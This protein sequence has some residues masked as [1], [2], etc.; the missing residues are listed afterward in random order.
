M[1]DNKDLKQA[2]Q[3]ALGA[4]ENQPLAD[5]AL[6]LLKTLGYHSERRLVLKPN[7]AD[8]FRMEFDAERQLNEE[9]ALVSA[10]K[11]VDVLFQITDSEVQQALKN[12]QDMFASKEVN[13]ADIRSYLFF[14]VELK[15]E[16][17]TRTQLAGITREINKL[18]P[19]PV[20]VIFRYNHV[21]SLGIITRRINKHD[22]NKDVLEKV[23][24]IKD[25]RFSG[26]R[27]QI[28][29]MHD[30]AISQLVEKHDL[31]NF[32]DLQ[33][34]WEKTLDT[35]E[36]NKKFYKEIANWYFWAVKTVKFP[37]DAEKDEETR[38]A[39][40]VIRLITR[41]IFVWFIKEKG[42]VPEEL[43]DK[44]WLDAVLKYE[45]PKKS[46]Y[47]KAI[48]QNLFF[49]TLN[50]EMG[51]GRIFRRK[52]TG[53]LDPDYL[54]SN[55]YRYKQYLKNP[56]KVLELFA[57]IPFLNGGLFECLD[58]EV[59]KGT[60]I[61]IDG[62]SERE[63]NPLSV[64]DD[65]FLLEKEKE[66]DLNEIYGTKNKKYKVRGILHILN[67]YKFTIEEN[68]PIE[69]EI[70][71][72]PE[73]LGKVFENLLAAYNPETGTT[74]R[75][76]TGSFYTPR[77]IV[78]YMVDEALVA[79][80]SS[81]LG[82]Q[83]AEF[84]DRLRDLLSYNEAPHAFSE[85]ETTLLIAA[86][87]KVK[88]LDPAA[89]SGAFP[90]GVLHKLVFMLNKLDPKNERWKQKQIAKALEMDSSQS[91]EA[92][93]ASIE[94]VF[95]ENHD[96]YGRKLYLIENCIYGVD[97]QPIA[98]QIAKL[99]FFIS[100]V[101]DQKTNTK[102]PNLGI[103][104]LPNLETKFV[105]ANTLIGIQR[106][107][108]KP[109]DEAPA[110]LSPEVE[111]ACD[112]LV[113][114]LEQYLKS[115][116]PDLRA[117]YTVEAQEYADTINANMG[118]D[119]TPLN[120]NWLFTTATDTKTLKALLPKKPETKASVLVLRNQEIDQKE[121]ELERV[122]REH[123]SART[124]T[125]KR[126]YRDLDKKLRAEIS[127]LLKK[128]GWGS[129]SAQQL[130][131]WDPYNQNAHADFFDP[132]WMFG[133][134]GG[135]DVVIGNPPYVQLQK[136][137]GH[138]GK[139]F[140]KAGYNTFE[141]TGDIYSLFYERG[142]QIL[143]HKGVLCFITSNKWMR[144]GYGESTRKFF[145][146]NTNPILLIDFA[147]QKIFEAATVDVNILMFSKDKNQHKTLACTIKED[148]LSNLS[149]FVRQAG[150]ICSFTNTNSWVIL[151]DIEQRIKEKIERIG[152]PL[153]HWD[154]QIN[155][156]IKTGF[157]DAFIIDGTK[158][159]ELIAQ[160]PKSDEIIRPI[161]R[162]RDIK[163]YGYDFAD[164]WLINTHNGIKEKGI[165]PVN[166][167]EYP[168]IKKHLD[169]FWDKIE[170][171]T[172]QGDTP[173]NLRNCAYME[174]FSKQKIIYPDIMRMPRQAELLKEYPYFY[175]DVKNFYVEATNFIMTGVDI[176]LVFLFLVSDLGFY[177]FS[178]F[179]AGPQF[180]ATGFRYKKVYIDETFIPK[181]ADKQPFLSIMDRL[182]N[183]ED[184]NEQINKIWNEIIDLNPE[185]IR[186]VKEYKK[187][188]LV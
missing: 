148:V 84:E 92:S 31:A 161:L 41:L 115:R 32:V 58:K 145:A 159:K 139:M 106:P 126:K 109:V 149:V 137:G 80:L 25:I 9:T 13:G 182:R 135:F 14:A 37:K 26:N 172:D 122:R 33:K 133:I 176:E 150:N 127:E 86:I 47:Y 169:K 44:R 45:D 158:R 102:L 46:T 24:L 123:F 113:R 166:I 117:K 75:K 10:W 30:L 70:A 53:G 71:L 103:L 118:A 156:G 112:M 29:I 21:V 49:A 64:P 73:L 91:R 54:M 76:Q 51:E 56:D 89:G 82:K 8:Q 90:M 12:T 131:S 17:Y 42:L 154:V 22:G 78:N 151:S 124:P 88:V 94:Q 119:F 111:E 153:K 95:A 138:Y 4:F 69:E 1:P 105:A 140:D 2:I 59:E 85:D 72:D 183:G 108:A 5:A 93:I 186:F 67:S 23:T 165:K 180:D 146:E 65:L 68:T 55:Y 185:E 144:A 174:D 170:P 116:N 6:G 61:R 114:K 147:G 107:D 128:D 96:D 99:R 157:N 48:L 101:V 187:N 164:V 178:K 142:W 130:A 97:I 175:F 28:E 83:N 120:A 38:N 62:F 3:N 11:S 57:G 77:E 40:S 141:L 87:D 168:A 7:S 98:V 50:T 162:G 36:L 143:K 34:A 60:V 179:Y 16:K 19:M 18:F 125:T 27:A 104:P 52:N 160:D 100:L 35:N 110:S 39:T 63:D 129:E 181:P 43:F 134:E 74:A 163:R 171:R 173:Y 177:A 152:T 167:K 15:G 184:V 79:Y 136:D 66:L 132:E 155:Y 81:E 121:K 188:L 20:M